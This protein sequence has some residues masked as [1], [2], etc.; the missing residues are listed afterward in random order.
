MDRF[1]TSPPSKPPPAKPAKTPHE[2]RKQND[3][4][5]RKQVERLRAALREQCWD[6]WKKHHENVACSCPSPLER[7]G[8]VK[9][10]KRAKEAE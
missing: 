8:V 6:C 4:K 2:I 5:K 7:F 3:L 1:V 10:E 9:K